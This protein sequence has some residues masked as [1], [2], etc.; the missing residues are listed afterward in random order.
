[1]NSVNLKLFCINHESIYM[2]LKNSNTYMCRIYYL[3]SLQKV[4]LLYYIES[5]NEVAGVLLQLL[6]IGALIVG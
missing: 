2:H 5:F 1:M 6:K 4:C 3:S